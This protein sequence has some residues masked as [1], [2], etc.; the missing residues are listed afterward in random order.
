MKYKATYTDISHWQVNQYLQTG[1][2]RAKC[3]VVN[4]STG[5]L[6]FFKESHRN[7]DSEFWMEIIASKVGQSLGLNMLDYNIARQNNLIGCLS[8]NMA[9]NGLELSELMKFFMGY[10]PTYNPDQKDKKNQERYTLSFIQKTLEHYGLGHHIERFI[11]V[12]VFDS[13]IGNQDRH[14]ENWG[15]IIPSSETVQLR[16]KSITRTNVKWINRLINWI[17]FFAQKNRGTQQTKQLEQ[18]W[19]KAYFSPIYDS[20]SCLGRE[21][22][23]DKIQQLLNNDFQMNAYINRCKAEI[24]LDGEKI[25]YF[26]LLKLLMKDARY[27]DITKD[28]IK[29]ICSN[30][31]INTITDIVTN[32][33]K[34]L[35]KHCKNCKLTDNRKKFIV[36]LLTLRY[37]KLNKLIDEI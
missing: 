29:Y 19:S 8:D 16:Q 22:T 28:Q 33:D 4:P 25:S 11:Q 30:F 6:C 13:I 1:G 5:R 34:E 2:T 27:S 37:E 36:K 26:E 23:E 24:R 31:N 21:N 18:N 35:P 9:E 7:Y 20:G 32:I 14:Q 15:F 10:D 3:W 12:I 17:I